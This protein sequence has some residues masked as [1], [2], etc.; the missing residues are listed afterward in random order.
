MDK[1]LNDLIDRY[2]KG[3]LSAEEKFA[4]EEMARQSE[5]I[6]QLVDDH[7]EL[8]NVMVENGQRKELKKKLDG[9]HEEMIETPVKP[10]VVEKKSQWG[11][12]WK[13]T[14]VAASVALFS[15]VGTTLVINY[16][17]SLQEAKLRPLRRNIDQIKRSQRNL[18]K[19]LAE[20][21][22]KDVSQGNYA[23]TCFMISRE[24]Y[25]VTSY[26]VVKDA[27][28]IKIENE[29][30]GVLNAS[31]QFND[32]ANDISVIKIDTVLYSLPFMVEAIDANLAEDVF[33]LGYPREDVVFG[34]GAVSAL[35]GYNQNPNSYQVS[36]P[37]NPGNSGGPLLNSKG[38]LVGIISGLQTETLGA[39]FAI[40]SNIIIDIVSNDSLKNYVFL[41]KQNLLKGGSRVNQVK[42][43]RDYV[44]M[45]RVFK[46]N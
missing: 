22:K 10:I 44:F 45:V 21:K 39:A 3:Q 25:L 6:R 40:K 14:A 17:N 20:T 29:K 5:T 30:F 12:Y 9:F 43:L 28:S 38:N 15:V 19:D 35:T 27:D 37:V 2:A 32:P 33:T 11:R 7:I 42:V 34:E 4:L 26:H 1:D 8:V 23:G 41:P 18:E 36:V 24:G 46:N 31:I 16:M 13:Y